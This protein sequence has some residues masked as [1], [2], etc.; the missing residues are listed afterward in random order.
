MKIYI[1]CIHIFYIQ[2][3][4][5]PAP[6]YAFFFS[7]FFEGGGGEI[8]YRVTVSCLTLYTSII[9][10]FLS[11]WQV[12]DWWQMDQLAQ[13]QASLIFLF[14]FLIRE[15]HLSD[16]VLDF[17]CTYMGVILCLNWVCRYDLNS[18]WYEKF[19][20]CTD[21]TCDIVCS[22]WGDHVKI[23]LLTSFDI[24][25]PLTQSFNCRWL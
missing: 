4:V 12:T 15:R 11:Q 2:K 23:K 16:L 7:F 21:F 9:L 10:S 8:F 17:P 19:K 13:V 25:W 18:F 5:F 22:S 6:V 24:S 1:W 3:L 14:H 20:M